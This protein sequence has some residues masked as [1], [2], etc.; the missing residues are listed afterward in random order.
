MV[1]PAG[2]LPTALLHHGRGHSPPEEDPC[3]TLYGHLA[4]ANPQWRLPPAG[5]AMA[6]F[7]GPDAYVSPAWYPSKQEHQKVVPTWN[8]VAVHAYGPLEF[9]ED[10]DRLLE[11]VTRLTDLHERPRAEPWTVTDAPE[12]FVRAQLRGIVGLRL[13]IARLE[14][15][16]KMSQNRSAPDRA[17]V[18]AGLAESDLASDRAVA[19]L[20]ST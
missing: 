18:A 10:A 11:V 1:T 9:F 8:Y 4:R 16:R 17:G 15:K 12:A 19:A 2:H 13:P 7:M 6:L 14:G 20:I 3:G 5:D